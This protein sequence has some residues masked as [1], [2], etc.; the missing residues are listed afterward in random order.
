MEKPPTLFARRSKNGGGL[1]VWC[2]YCQR[3]HHHGR[4]RNGG[5]CTYRGLH[6]ERCTCPVG[7]G[8]GHRVAHCAGNNDSLY[9][10]TGYILVE[11]DAKAEKPPRKLKRNELEKPLRCKICRDDITKAPYVHTTVRWVYSVKAGEEQQWSESSFDY[12]EA[13]AEKAYVT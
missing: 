12:H 4:H 13:C 7:S 10:D 1:D 2:R 9:Q 6:S 8:D 5:E 11:D 3:D